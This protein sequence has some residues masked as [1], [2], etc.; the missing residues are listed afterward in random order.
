MNTQNKVKQLSLMGLFTAIIFVLA[1]TPFGYIQLPFI[2]ATIIHIPVIIG[3][4]LLGA[5][6]G[7]VLG[8]LFGLTSLINNTITPTISSFVFSP[9]ILIPT[10]GSGSPLALI[11]CFIPRILVGILP[12]IAYRG[13]KKLCGGRFEVISLAI[14]GVIG[15]L[16]NTLLVMSLIFF[17]FKDAYASVKNVASDAVYTVILSIIAVN[18][19]PEAIA[20]GILTAATC[21]SV[22][23]LRQCNII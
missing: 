5:R 15:S 23:F 3:S 4:I 13:I 2:K 18:G 1:F 9:F 7:S 22:K 19:I 12:A 17:L 8:F 10:T 20:A 21:I 6:H 16:T 14:S 11:I